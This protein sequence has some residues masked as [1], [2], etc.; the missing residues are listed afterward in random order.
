MAFKYAIALT[1]GIATGKSSATIILSLYG[2]R[3]IDADK[4]AHQ[5]LDEQ[6][7]A[8]GEMFGKE[9][10]YEGKVDRK[11]LG[12]IV[13]SDPVKRKEL[14]AFLHPLIYEEIE[15]QA[16]IQEEFRKPYIIDIPLFFEGER[17]PIEKSLV[18]Y[19]PKEEQLK[20]LMRRDGYDEAE[21]RKRID[22]QMDIELK[23]QKATYVIDNSGDLKQLQ[24]ECERVKE[25]ILKDFS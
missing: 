13:F 17:Y 9:L 12:K 25:A 4:I 23:R 22:L 5:I 24:H 20:R 3:F 6:S 8:I 1:G 16:L 7:F 14:E 19:T 11:A 15:C 10:V 21:A 18:I 2:F